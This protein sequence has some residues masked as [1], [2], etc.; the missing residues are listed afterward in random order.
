MRWAPD[1]TV[2]QLNLA[3]SQPV[4]AINNGER[5]AG[6]E[7]LGSRLWTYYNGVTTW[8]SSPEYIAPEIVGM[9]ACGSIAAMS[10]LDADVGY[11]WRAS[12]ASRPLGS[13][14]LVL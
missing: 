6:H 2:V 4:D 12:S 1:G 3:P 8:F 10:S 14:W 5:L 7:Q 13:C 11:L 9:D